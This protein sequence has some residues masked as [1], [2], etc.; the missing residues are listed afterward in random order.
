M[1][2]QYGL[3][4]C[5]AVMEAA[6]IRFLAHIGINFTPIGP[7]VD[8]HGKR[9][10]CIIEVKYLLEGVKNKNPE[11][12]DLLTDRGTFWRSDDMSASMR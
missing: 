2:F 12:W 1:I 11:I 10:P 7:A 5:Y 3:T 4:H 9:Q 6:L 8:Y